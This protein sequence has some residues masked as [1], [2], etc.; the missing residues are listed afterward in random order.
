MHLFKGALH[1][2]INADKLGIDIEN[3][4][5]SPKYNIIYNAKQVFEYSIKDEPYLDNPVNIF[6]KT[7]IYNV[8]LIK[9]VL[10]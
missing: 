9:K 2:I 5:S 1:I 8:E 4:S 6:D 7:N 3:C 10:I